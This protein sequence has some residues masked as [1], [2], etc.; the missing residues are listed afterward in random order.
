M[1]VGIVKKIDTRDE[2]ARRRVAIHETGH[3]LLSA[4][5][6]KYF[7]LKKVS[8][9]STLNISKQRF[10]FLIKSISQ[11]VQQHDGCCLPK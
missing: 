10:S 8:I 1:I 7:E 9:Q 3:A 2:H 4:L 11:K 6:D 5:F